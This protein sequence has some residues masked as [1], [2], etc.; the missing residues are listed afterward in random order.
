[1]KLF[2]HIIF[3]EMSQ[4]FHDNFDPFLSSSEEEKKSKIDPSTVL[5][6]LNILCCIQFQMRK[7]NIQETNQ[8]NFFSGPV[9]LI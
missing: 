9:F 1:M 5:T 8:P 6:C 7:F 3:D 2:V 4:N